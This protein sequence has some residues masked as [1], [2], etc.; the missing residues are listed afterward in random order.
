MCENKNIS[1]NELEAECWT[2]YHSYLVGTISINRF[3]NLF[4]IIFTGLSIK[5]I[6]NAIG[7]NS[8]TMIIIFTTLNAGLYN[9]EHRIDGI[10]WYFCSFNGCFNVC[11][12]KACSW[13]F[14][15]ECRWYD[16]SRG[17]ACEI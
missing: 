8:T 15:N 2:R 10:L 13:Y 3:F 7:V 1:I 12:G 4:M 16:F 5:Q 11:I 17:G 6:A 9:N 14:F